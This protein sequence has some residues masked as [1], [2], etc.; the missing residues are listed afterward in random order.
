MLERPTL[1]REDLPFRE[2]FFILNSARTYG[3][4]AA[5]PLQVSEILSLVTM[6]GIA[7]IGDKSK[8]LRLMQKLD[9]TY[10]S[11]QSDKA[12]KPKS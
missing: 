6:G 12:T 1:K 4:S 3:M 5:N 10:L 9:Q 11:F 7:Y 2:A 8:Y